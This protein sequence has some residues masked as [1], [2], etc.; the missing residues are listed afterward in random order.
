L[1]HTKHKLYFLTGR[2]R[3]GLQRAEQDSRDRASDFTRRPA[4]EHDRPVAV[5]NG[6]DG[7]L[8][9]RDAVESRYCEKSP[10]SNLWSI[11]AVI[12][13]LWVNSSS[14]SRK[15]IYLF[16]CPSLKLNLMLAC[17]SQFTNLI[18]YKN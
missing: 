10:S 7:S 1:H 6:Q 8:R 17:F 2:L 16:G 11:F 13:V 15:E 18:W 4:A 9:A 14:W 5:W 12:I 3:D